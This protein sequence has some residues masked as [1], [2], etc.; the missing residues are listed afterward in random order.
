MSYI[1]HLLTRI[2]LSLKD[3]IFI[4]AIV[5]IWLYFAGIH[6]YLEAIGALVIFDVITGEEETHKGSE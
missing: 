6:I 1:Q 3:N 2:F 4:K 5:G